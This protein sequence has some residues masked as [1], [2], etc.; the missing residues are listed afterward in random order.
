MAE[1]CA[2]AP[3]LS[4]KYNESHVATRL[5]SA[6]D[7]QVTA[8]IR[9]D[10]LDEDVLPETEIVIAWLAENFPST[11][12]EYHAQMRVELIDPESAE[13][14]TVGTPDLLCL[15]RTDPRIS[16]VDYKKR[17]QLFAGHLPPPR[18]NLQLLAYL[19][20]A[21]SK[22]S[23]ERTIRQGDVTL[24]CWDDR[25]VTALKSDPIDDAGLWGIIETIRAIPPMDLSVQ[26]EASIGDHCDHCYGR[27]HCD[28]HLLPLAVVI[29]A[30]LPAPYAEFIDPEKPLVAETTVKALAWLEGAKRVLSEAKKI[31]DLVEG[32][33]DAFVTQNGPVVVGE[34]AYGPQ[35]VKGKRA[36]AT[37]KTLEKEGLTRLIRDGE[38][39]VKCKWF[40][41]PKASQP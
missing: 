28:A 18:E 2:R 32:N 20:A 33:A 16:I 5:G 31:V 24:C 30:G 29:Q 22:L 19:A 15:H 3:W 17:G 23:T 13:I 35:E 37:I 36:G 1:H 34:L 41:A 21:W 9:G 6:V 38:T 39:K 12:W 14:L 40:P 25:G 11:E 8:L 4:A 7:G 10:D 26:P 27:M